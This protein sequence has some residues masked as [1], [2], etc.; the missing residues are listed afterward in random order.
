MVAGTHTNHRPPLAPLTS[1]I[2]KN[3]RL[4]PSQDPQAARH[5]GEN[6]L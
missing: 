5:A 1:Q 3:S 4:T 2:T 6:R